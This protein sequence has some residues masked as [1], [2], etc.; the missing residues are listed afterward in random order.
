M[1]NELVIGRHTFI[2]VGPPF[3][4]YELIVVRPAADGT[5]VERILLTPATDACFHPATI[6]TTNAVLKESVPQ[7]LGKI[8][9]C[10][11]PENKLRKELDRRK[12][13]LVFSGADVFL[14]V[15]CQGKP[16]VIRADIL[17][18][19]MFDT[20]PNT[21]EY[22]SW[23]MQI[24]ERIDKA[25]GPGVSDRPIFADFASEKPAAQNAESRAML[26][27]KSGTYDTLFQGSP[28]LPSDLYRL[29]QKHPA[30]PNAKLVRSV[31]FEPEVYVA[32]KYP[33][34]A[35]AAHV[36]GEVAFRF[37]IAGNCNAEALSFD[38]GPVMLRQAVETAVKDWKFCR[39]PVG[40]EIQA[41]IA[42]KLDCP[43][44]P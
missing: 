14:Q 31:P 11:I 32:P 16:R 9:P 43:A 38:T 29:A 17:D 44:T 39:A 35:K 7:L 40:Q 2:D 5:A 21:P 15:Q 23:T 26:E 27:V 24:L 20:A 6:E 8:N 10:S 4:Y 33:P 42:F 41:R 1:P 3:N 34:I 37:K 19:D 22:T 18:R 12:K 25:T 28:D 30:I 13:G 36:E